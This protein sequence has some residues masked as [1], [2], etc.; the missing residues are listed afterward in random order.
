MQTKALVVADAAS[1]AKATAPLPSTMLADAAR[2]GTA[3]AP[4]HTGAPVV[5][6]MAASVAKAGATQLMPTT[7]ASAPLPAEAP[8]VAGAASVAKAS[9]SMPAEVPQ[10]VANIAHTATPAKRVAALKKAQQERHL[11]AEELADLAE[12]NRLVKEAHSRYMRYYRSI[13]S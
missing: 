8:Q 10:V 7:A 13:R 3:T 12:Q 5:A 4:T 2:V 1:M 11:T 9:A 6:D